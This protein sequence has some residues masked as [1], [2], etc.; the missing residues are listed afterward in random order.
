MAHINLAAWL[1]AGIC[2]DCLGRTFIDGPP[3]G[4]YRNITCSGCRRKF[5]VV[6]IL[7]R[8]LFVQRIDVELPAGKPLIDLRGDI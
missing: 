6:R 4:L 5:N 3:A 2:Q 1:N 7:G 8:V